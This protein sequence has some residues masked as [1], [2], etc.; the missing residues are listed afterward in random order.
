MS[1]QKEHG[2]QAVTPPQTW[3]AE[4]QQ[5]PQV[6]LQQIPCSQREAPPSWRTD[7]QGQ[8]GSF[9]QQHKRQKGVGEAQFTGDQQLRY[10]EPR[11]HQQGHGVGGVG[12]WLL[13]GED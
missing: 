2:F 11:S 12:T 3:G 6:T 7:C 1:P 4:P 10:P 13:L 9:S 5:P 8:W